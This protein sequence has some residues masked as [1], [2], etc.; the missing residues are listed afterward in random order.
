MTANRDAAAY[1]N[2]FSFFLLRVYVENTV[3][4]FV[5]LYVLIAAKAFARHLG[6]L[7]GVC[8]TQSFFCFFFCF[9]LFPGG[10]STDTDFSTPSNI[11]R[12]ILNF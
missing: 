2:F 11:H 10:I 6:I 1:S 7:Y 4:F 9:L 8:K 5:C 12:H 3:G